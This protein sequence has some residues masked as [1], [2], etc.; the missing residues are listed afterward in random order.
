LVPETILKPFAEPEFIRQ[1]ARQIDL[2]EPKMIHWDTENVYSDE[3]RFTAYPLRMLKASSIPAVEISID[4]TI[5]NE[6]PCEN[7]AWP[8]KVLVHHPGNWPFVSEKS[9]VVSSNV[10][11][12]L[13]ITPKVKRTSANLKSYSRNT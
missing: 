6:V 5:D 2:R 10:K 3:G 1:F 7:D 13:K 4:Y 9:F 11:A 8:F 12:T